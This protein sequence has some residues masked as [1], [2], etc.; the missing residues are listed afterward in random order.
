[1]E[2]RIR[3]N[4]LSTAI[5]IA[6]GVVVS[7]ITSTVVA[8]RAYQSRVKQVASSQRE[9][10]VKGSARER[11]A[12]D[13][14]MWT[15]TVSGE[16][17]TLPEAFEVL[18]GG[19]G[20]VA[21]FLREQ[22]FADAEVVMEAIETKNHYATDEKGNATWR[23]EGYGL[24]RRVTVTSRAV[25]KMATAAGEVTKLIKDGVVVSS[26]KPRFYFTK[27]ADLKVK[28]LGEAAKDAMTRAVEIAKNSG[29]TVGGVRNVQMGVLQITEPNSTE[30]SGQ[31]IYDTDTI[32]KDVSAVVTVT[33][34]VDA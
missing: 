22:G 23:V 7:T 25:G 21:A 2:Y 13:V 34:G 29:G 32:E 31:G 8:A 18:D 4:L 26:S 15:V 1:M 17:K 28:I 10:S 12:S 9:I 24:S 14:G 3:V 20:K 5:V 6:I 19:A 33:Y 11:V 30:V 27:I 16:G